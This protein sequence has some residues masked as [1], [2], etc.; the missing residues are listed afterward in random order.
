MPGHCQCKNCQKFSGGGHASLFM[1]PAAAFRCSGEASSYDYLADS[2][3]MVRRFF[4]PRCGAP[5]YN[6]NSGMPGAVF[7]WAG[8]LD[9]P[10][11]FE[12]QLVVYAASAQPWDYVDSRLPSFPRMPSM[13]P[14]GTDVR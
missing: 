11:R 3:N 4:C 10:A 12:P 2:G 5:V 7:P 1:I 9:E 6:T 8:S 14:P 13:T